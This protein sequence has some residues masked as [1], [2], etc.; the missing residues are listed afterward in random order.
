V[1]RKHG[2]A[3]FLDDDAPFF[4]VLP[5]RKKMRGRSSPFSAVDLGVSPQFDP[6]DALQ[7]IFPDAYGET[8]SIP[9]PYIY[10]V[11][12]VRTTIDTFS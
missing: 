7:L 9:G 1:G 5:Q 8:L 12:Q 10:A 3:A 11:F 4:T 6:V 2:A